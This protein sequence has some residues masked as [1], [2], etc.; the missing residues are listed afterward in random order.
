MKTL[1]ALLLMS[2]G[3]SAQAQECPP[4]LDY[5]ARKLHSEQTLDL[6]QFSGK[7]VLAVNTASQCGYTPQFKA[8]E[9]LYKEFSDD[10]LVI[11][12]FPSDDFRQEFGDEEKTASVCYINYG[13]TFPM[14]ATT[15]VTGDGANPVFRQL[16]A[17]LQAPSWNFNKYLIGRD[18]TALVHFPSNVRPDDARL[19]DAVREALAE[20]P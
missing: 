11:I 10:G 15:S 13:V 8:L 7:V 17:A 3:M 9:A 5:Q 18:G 19:V 16:N 4:I 20:T 6:C 1:V 12:G 14:L 2:L